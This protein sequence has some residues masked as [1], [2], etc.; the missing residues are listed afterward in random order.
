MRSNSAKPHASSSQP[1]QWNTE[2]QEALNILLDCLLRPPI[3]GYPDYSQPFE[4]HTDASHQGL[5]AVLYQKQDGKMRVMGYASRSLAPAEKKYHAGKLEFLALR[6][7]PLFFWRGGW[8]ILKK[9]VCKDKKV[10]INCLQSLTK[11]KK[12]C[13]PTYADTSD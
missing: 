6:D 8:K 10:Q 4:L 13:K 3:L 9:I 12:V 7:G 2:H 11:E 1:I 5:G